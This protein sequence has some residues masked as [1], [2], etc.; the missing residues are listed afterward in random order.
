MGKTNIEWT[1]H[2]WPVLNGCLR[3]S[4]GCANCYAE[5][6]TA[7]RLRHLP[8]Y[9]GLAQWSE[10]QGG[11]GWT[12]ESRLWG[13]DLKM[14]LR[15]RSP[16]RI[17]VCDMGDLFFEQNTNEQIAAV[18]G[19]M[20]AAPQH[21]FQVLT[22]R[23]ERMRRWF[24]WVDSFTAEPLAAGTISRCELCA[25]QAGALPPGTHQSRRLLNDLDKHGYLVF[26]QWPLR[27]VHLGVSV[28]DQQRAD[29]RIPHL[30][31]TPAT[32]RFL[33]CEP[34][35]EKIN[36]RHL[37]ADRAGH[38][39]MCQVDALTGRHSD[40]GRPCRDVARIDWVIVGG[41]S[42]PGARP[43]DVRW[44]HDI[45]EQCRAAGVP[46]FVKQLGSRPL[47]VRSLKDR[48][49]G[50]MSE[51]PAGLRARMMPGD[52]WPVCPCMTDVEDPGPHIDGCG[53]LSR[54]A[55]EMQEMP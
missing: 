48:K 23:T 45:V 53:Y 8:K 50:D 32:V 21:T 5:R 30:L 51:W 41:E 47:G 39:S 31:Q 2:S 40:M 10:R 14:P 4:P 17:F 42:G 46:A 26:Q 34:L 16:S 24:M 49:G 15:L 18:F 11:P 33:S 44:V 13:K 54:V 9:A 22:K 36:L 29:E 27:N 12:G 38:T 43:C 20:A 28:E 55:R 19:V 6:L 1:D 37:D 52:T 35:L 3:T 7:T 25:E